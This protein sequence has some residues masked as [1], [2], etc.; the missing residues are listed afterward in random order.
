V[1]RLIRHISE[2]AVGVES[3]HILTGILERRDSHEALIMHLCSTHIY[4]T[5]VLLISFL[6]VLN[7]QGVSKML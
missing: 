4:Q 1:D 6:G 7:I 5:N 2:S 3:N